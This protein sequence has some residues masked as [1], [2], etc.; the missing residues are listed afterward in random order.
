MA[1]I[2]IVGAGVSGLSAGI[3]LLKAGHEV[4]VYDMQAVAGGNLTSWKRKGFIIDN[5]V[6]WLTGTN[7]NSTLYKKWR[8]ANIITDDG[9]YKSEYLYKSELLGESL[10]LY[11]DIE[12]TRREMLKLSPAD[13]KEINDFISAVKCFKGYMGLGGENDNKGLNIFTAL[14]SVKYL[15]KYN[16]MS[17]NELASRF[18]NPLI[19]AF[20]TDYIGGVF[21]A[22]AYILT[23]ATYVSGNGDI[24]VGSSP[25]MANDITAKFLGLGGKLFLNS[26]VEK[27]FYKNG[28]VTKLLLLD[29]SLAYG[30]YFIF[31]GDPFGIYFKI[32]NKPM[33]KALFR[34]FNDK[35]LERFSSMH[36]A[37]GV[38]IADLPFK[39]TVIFNAL[40]D[41]FNVLNDTRIKLR[42][43]SRDES[44]APSGKTVIQSISFCN[45]AFSRY[46]IKLAENN[47]KYQKFK[48]DY[49]V[50]VKESIENYYP[51]LKGKLTFLDCW[52]PYTYKRYTG[53]NLGEYM[54][55]TLPKNYAP[56]AITGRVKGVKNAVVASQWLTVPG[57]LPN[58]LNSGLKASK[59][60]KFMVVKDG[61]F[62]PRALPVTKSPLGEN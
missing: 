26:K 20:F 34:R 57:G 58:A 16:N 3:N 27:A 4:S 21:G 9:V 51:N 43:Y 45:Q 44:L 49:V 53:A 56:T 42:E 55:F 46:I 47:E 29:G 14:S 13:E 11:R 59:T 31:T 54:S 12:K 48:R 2:V 22:T 23:A 36:V 28:R 32:L 41:K 52:T 19:K 33:P 24:P 25:K 40:N 7:P 60:V 18:S 17:L 15:V 62:K 35:R 5:C 30:D 8:N 39:E 10:A 1:K 6:H 50:A 38:N 37:F 61:L